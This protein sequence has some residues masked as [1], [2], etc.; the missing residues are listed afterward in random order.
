MVTRNVD[1]RQNG[2]VVRM[3][4]GDRMAAFP[5][6]GTC[7]VGV[8]LQPNGLKMRITTSTGTMRRAELREVRDTFDVAEALDMVEKFLRTFKV[9]NA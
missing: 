3:G 2:S 7:T 8:E 5:R 4:G 6:T 1:T 9:T